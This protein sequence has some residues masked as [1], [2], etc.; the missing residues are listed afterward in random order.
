MLPRLLRNLLIVGSLL[1]SWAPLQAQTVLFNSNGF[2][3]PY[4][5]GN[6]NGQQSWIAQGSTAAGSVVN[7][8]VFAG[9]QSMRVNG[10]QLTSL[11]LGG[12]GSS[13]WTRVLAP[14]LAASFKPVAAGQP[15]VLV[16]WHQFITGSTNDVQNMPYSGIHIEGFRAD[17]QSQMTTEIGVDFTDSIGIFDGGS[18]VTGPVIPGLRNSWLDLT[19]RLDYT[20]QTLELF[21]NGASY[22]ADIPFANYIPSQS[23]ADSIGV[24]E[25]DIWAVSGQLFTGQ[26]PNN[27][28]FFDNFNVIAVAV[29]E[30]AAIALSIAGVGL[31]GAWC[32]RRA[33]RHQRLSDSV[34]VVDDTDEL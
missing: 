15:V 17:G 25:S 32:W 11:G 18:Y 7:T 30:P 1:V 8:T 22:L 13:F 4:T 23:Q 34:I 12:S 10:P 20:T 19:A 16:N 33:R 26:I 29:P 6:I 2:E 14:N 27:V 5:L 9:T 24:A 21:V 31:F 28:A 3:P